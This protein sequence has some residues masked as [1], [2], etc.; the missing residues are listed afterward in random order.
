MFVCVGG[1]VGGGL[2]RFYKAE[3]P[4]GLKSYIDTNSTCFTV[5]SKAIK[6]RKSPFG[7]SYKLKVCKT[8][9]FSKK[10]LRN[11]HNN[12]DKM[13]IK[14]SKSKIFYLSLFF[15]SFS[16]FNASLTVVLNNI[17]AY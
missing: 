13:N 17:F 7:T 8:L 16:F 1:G 14:K 15:Y 11:L 10:L 9:C 6:L 5:T 2:K 4:I 3:E 12:S